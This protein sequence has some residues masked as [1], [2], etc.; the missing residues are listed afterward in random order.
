MTFETDSQA[1]T[2]SGNRLTEESVCGF[3]LKPA[4]ASL[5]HAHRDF[6]RRFTL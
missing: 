1:V 6:V 5:D 4:H 2:T 3:P